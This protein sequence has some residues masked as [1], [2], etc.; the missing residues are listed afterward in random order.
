[1]RKSFYNVLV[2]AG[3]L[4][5]L[6]MP[7]A[8]AEMDVKNSGDNLV[9]AIFGLP[10]AIGRTLVA[11]VSGK[12]IVTG[13]QGLP[14]LKGIEAGARSAFD[15]VEYATGVIVPYETP[16]LSKQGNLDAAFD[17]AGLAGRVARGAIVY[18]K[19][20]EIA[21]HE[22]SITILGDTISSG[23]GAAIGASIGGTAEA[24]GDLTK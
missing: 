3:L 22:E 9:K 12:D 1:M 15:E 23:E 13:E 19:V 7:S 24:V 21:A 6:Y 4:S 20:G 14:I 17:E 11:T 8:I 10:R 18:G 2:G 16:D 5:C